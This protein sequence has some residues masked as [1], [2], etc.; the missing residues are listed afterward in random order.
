MY[1][2]DKEP[3]Y[4]ITVKIDVGEFFEQKKEDVY[5]VLREMST[6]EFLQF[7]QK[8]IMNAGGKDI[9][10]ETKDMITAIELSEYI[11]DI[12]G[13]IIIDH[14]FYEAENKKMDSREVAKII[15]HKFNICMYVLKEYQNSTL[16]IEDKKK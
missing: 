8:N 5:I 16:R 2:R 14:N 6:K 4:L 1:I 13:N 11:V 15:Q 7:Q 10:K 12:L 3:N 9:N